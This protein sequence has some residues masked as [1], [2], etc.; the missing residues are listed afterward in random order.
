MKLRSLGPLVWALSVLLATSCGAGSGTHPIA[1]ATAAAA[2]AGPAIPAVPT[3]L[4]VSYIGAEPAALPI[5]IAQDAGIFQ[6]HG[7]D[8]DLQVIAGLRRSRR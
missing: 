6:K 5:L 2:G 3:K 1:S 7:L 4:T 8:V